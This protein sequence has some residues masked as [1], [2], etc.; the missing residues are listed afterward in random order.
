[1]KSVLISGFIV[2]LTQS[3]CMASEKEDETAKLLKTHNVEI[4]QETG[5]KVFYPKEYENYQKFKEECLGKEFIAELLGKRLKILN[6]Y[7]EIYDKNPKES[8]H[9]YYKNLLSR[10]P[11]AIRLNSSP[12]IL[13]SISFIED[14]SYL[15]LINHTLHIASIL[16]EILGDRSPQELSSLISNLKRNELIIYQYMNQESGETANEL[17]NNSLVKL[18]SAIGLIVK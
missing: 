3:N 17:F 2:L 6:N 4:V 1:M 5:D 16:K 7:L 13:S 9:D 12:D 11:I 8:D 10:N 18:N 15:S 14:Y